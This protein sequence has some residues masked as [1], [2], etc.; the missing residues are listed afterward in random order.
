MICEGK[1]GDLNLYRLTNIPKP[2]IVFKIMIN[3]VELKHQ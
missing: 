3:V 2:K 1:F